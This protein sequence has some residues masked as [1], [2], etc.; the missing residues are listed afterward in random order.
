MIPRQRISFYKGYL[1]D[2]FT[3]EKWIGS[4]EE[5]FGN[6]FGREAVFMSSGRMALYHILQELNLQKKDEVIVPAYTFYA[7][8]AVVTHF[9]KPVFVDIDQRFGLDVYKL[10]EA[11]TKNTKCIIATHLF[12]IPCDIREIMRVAKKHNLT[13]IEDCA[14]A[15]GA[16]VEDNK[17]G[18]FGDFAFFSFSETKLIKTFGGSM[19][20]TSKEKAQ[21][22]RE[23]LR[24]LP[25]KKILKDVLITSISAFFTRPVPFTLFVYPLL[26]FFSLFTDRDV[27]YDLM[28]EKHMFGSIHLSRPH[29]GQAK[30]G[31]KQ[32]RQIDQV[33]ERHKARMRPYDN[34]LANPDVPGQT[35][36]QAVILV[37]DRDNFARKLLWKG[38]DVQRESCHAIPYMP[39]FKAY[40]GNFPVAL[41][42]SQKIIHLP[43]YFDSTKKELDYIFRRLP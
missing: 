43:V 1:K 33:L 31:L 28:R 40:R 5:A 37:S 2:V 42:V 16:T 10:E 8:P 11:I 14:Q 22:M 34:R 26:L 6:Y 35:F 41:D 15:L 29:E 39:M 25:R 23:K 30:M 7:V 19:V 17:V 32:L 21:R 18:T 3:S 20:L 38:I 13:V 36:Q 4:F 9:C 24:R 12:G 27:L